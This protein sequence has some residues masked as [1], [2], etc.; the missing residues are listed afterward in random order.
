MFGYVLGKTMFSQR[1]YS[2]GICLSVV[3]VPMSQTSR[4]ILITFR[5]RR[6]IKNILESSKLWDSYTQTKTHNSIFFQNGFK[7]LIKFYPK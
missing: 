4:P 7:E 1:K 3:C 5:I 2:F 6:E